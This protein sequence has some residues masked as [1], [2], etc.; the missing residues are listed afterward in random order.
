MN[1]LLST[2][3]AIS[4]SQ[5]YWKSEEGCSLLSFLTEYLFLDVC[6]RFLRVDLHTNINNLFSIFP[7]VKH[8]WIITMAASFSRQL[9]ISTLCCHFQIL[10]P[11]ILSFMKTQKDKFLSLERNWKFTFF[12]YR[13]A[14]SLCSLFRTDM[15]YITVLKDKKKKWTPPPQKKKKQLKYWRK[16]MCSDDRYTWEKIN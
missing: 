9:F 12:T 8:N 1:H 4:P 6:K 5:G 2:S 7:Q 13:I 14:K 11:I 15:F 10:F 16:N 3:Q